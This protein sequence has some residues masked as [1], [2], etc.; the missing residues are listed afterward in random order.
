MHSQEPSD[1]MFAVGAA[2]ALLVVVLS[3]DAAFLSSDRNR[4]ASIVAVALSVPVVA[5]L[6]TVRRSPLPGTRALALAAT[7]LGIALCV[8]ETDQIPLVALFV[9]LTGAVD[10]W[11]R[12]KADMI[13][14][15]AAAGFVGWAGLYGSAGR[16]S[17]LVGALFAWW[18]LVLI[19]IVDRIRPLRS[20]WQF[21]GVITVGAIA[22]AAMARTGGISDSHSDAVLAAVVAAGLSLPIALGVNIGLD[23]VSSPPN[24]EVET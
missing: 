6:S 2:V 9:L 17:A 23:R 22:V 19:L 8:P 1:R 5:A 10:I 4:W 14:Y 15:G 16:G 12:G 21:L 24:G 13:W 7:L 11:R 20:T 3:F 18:V